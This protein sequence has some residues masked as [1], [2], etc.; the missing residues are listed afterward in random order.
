M[1]GQIRIGVSGWRYPPWRGHFYPKGLA[2]ARELA[3]AACTFNALELN[4]S[5]Y[6]LQRPHSYEHWARETPD[7]LVFAVKGGRYITHM[8]R[9]RD[10]EVALANFLASGVFALGRKLGPVL[11]QLPPNLAFDHGL[12][13][14]FLS[15]LPRTPRAA[16]ALARRHDGKLD[17]RA[18]TTVPAG[19]R[20]RHAVEVRHDSFACDAFVQLLRR[21]QVAWVV[22]DTPEPWPCYE[23]ATAD[24]VYLR[25]HGS[26]ALYQSRYGPKELDRWASLARSWAAGR[27]PRGAQ[28]IASRLKGRHAG[29]DVFC[30]FDN[31][32]KLHAP[33][34]AQELMQRLKVQ[35]DPGCPE[36][37]RGKKPS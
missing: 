22:A 8:L 21:H 33:A 29:R 1:A 31:T 9:L 30:F 37:R 13:D 34:N 32:D 4:G 19:T 25:L 20:F 11:W 17:G 10:V 2:Q 18:L 35:W 5:F 26:Q 12:M 27:Q 24:F 15:L 7:D 6:S 23:D 3:H 36:A 14:D 16:A 28:L